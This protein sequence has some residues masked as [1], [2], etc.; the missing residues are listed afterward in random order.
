MLLRAEKAQEYDQTTPRLDI[1][2]PFFE[3][4]HFDWDWSIQPL[5]IHK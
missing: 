4:L 1:S 3:V 2:V 5:Y